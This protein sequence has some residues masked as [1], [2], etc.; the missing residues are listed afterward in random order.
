M[1]RFLE[2]LGGVDVSQADGMGITI[3]RKGK[4]GSY[5]DSKSARIHRRN[6]RG[7]YCHSSTGVSRIPG[8]TSGSRGHEDG[9]D[10]GANIDEGHS[11]HLSG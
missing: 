9:M 1:G 10:V 3:L 7:D 6:S 8:V 5:G 2:W 4:D 11:C